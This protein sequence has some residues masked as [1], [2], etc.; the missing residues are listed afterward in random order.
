MPSNPTGGLWHASTTR[1]CSCDWP[2]DWL[3]EITSYDPA[4]RQHQYIATVHQSGVRPIAEAAAN[5][6]MMAAARQMADLIPILAHILDMSD[7]EHDDFADSAADCLGVLL[8]QHDQIRRLHRT[9]TGKIS[10]I[11][12]AGTP[13]HPCHHD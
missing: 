7:P 5:A 13:R 9:I 8:S 3:T 12:S 1:R 4:T 6:Q 2:F 10:N 11:A